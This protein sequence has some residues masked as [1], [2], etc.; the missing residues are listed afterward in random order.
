MVLLMKARMRAAVGATVGAIGGARLRS[1][2]CG[3]AALCFFRNRDAACRPLMCVYNKDAASPTAH[4]CSAPFHKQATQGRSKACRRR[5]CGSTALP[6][7]ARA[8]HSPP[9][10]LSN[11]CSVLISLRCKRYLRQHCAPT[12]RTQ[13][14]LTELAVPV[15]MVCL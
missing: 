13:P 4:V 8:L 14:A 6:Q 3:A 12:G 5:L 10:L 11:W 2:A 1:A 15:A 9:S 7:G